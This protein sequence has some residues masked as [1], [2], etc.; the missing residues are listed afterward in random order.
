M[1]N[2]R[3]TLHSDDVIVFIPTS[4][5]TA[6]SIPPQLSRPRRSLFA[7]YSAAAAAFVAMMP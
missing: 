3:N 6:S 2:G 1:V 7:L 5:F 4:G